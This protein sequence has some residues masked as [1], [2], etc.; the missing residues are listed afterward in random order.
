ML[1]TAQIFVNLIKS[2]QFLC[3]FLL[4]FKLAACEMFG[5]NVE[6]MSLTFPCFIYCCR[7]L[8]I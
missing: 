5:L 8:F 3:V 6:K 1:K 2:E 4:S 7:M